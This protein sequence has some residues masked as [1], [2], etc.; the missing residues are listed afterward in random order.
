LGPLR[1]KPFMRAKARP[2]GSSAADDPARDS[3]EPLDIR[4]IYDAHGDFIWLSLQRLG[5]QPADM[6]DVAQEVFMIVHRRLDSFDRKTRL[7]T[8][9]FGICL[10]VAANYRRRS[11]AR[12]EVLAGDAHDDRPSTLVAADDLLARREERHFA[13]WALSHL[14]VE[15]RATFVMFEV[16]SLACEEI[17]KIMNVPLGTVYS[18]LH[19]ARRQIEKVI[20]RGRR[21]RR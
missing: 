13:E 21:R 2:T 17:A 16:E 8:W 15:K 9:L 14:D 19:A 20:A 6:D 11:R 3:T 5:V 10:R 4:S 18:R 12:H 7:A 1:R